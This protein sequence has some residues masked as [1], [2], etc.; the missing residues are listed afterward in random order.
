MGSVSIDARPERE[1]LSGT[2]SPT[3]R[4]RSC[5][6]GRAGDTMHALGKYGMP[7]GLKH[8][9]TRWYMERGVMY[10]D[11]VRIFIQAYQVGLRDAAKEPPE[12]SAFRSRAE[13]ATS[14]EASHVGS[15]AR[16]SRR[17]GLGGAETLSGSGGTLGDPAHNSASRADAAHGGGRPVGGERSDLH[18]SGAKSK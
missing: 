6:F 16:A 2:E 18:P 9:L 14:H 7:E 3:F 12:V 4:G 10:R 8:G 15:S 5:R 1:G 13:E 11:A 17:D